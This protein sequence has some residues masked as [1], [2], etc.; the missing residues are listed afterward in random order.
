MDSIS[1]IAVGIGPTSGC[2]IC[3]SLPL[4]AVTFTNSEVNAFLGQCFLCER[5]P[6]LTIISY[7]GRQQTS[8]DGRLIYECLSAGKQLGFS[9]EN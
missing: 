7:H 4:R 3:G 9:S 8:L 5:L 6:C 2:S 1:V